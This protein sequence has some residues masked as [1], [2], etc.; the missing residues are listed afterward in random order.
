MNKTAFLTG[1]SSHFY[2]SAKRKAQDIVAQ[3]RQSLIE[4][5]L[6]FQ[7]QFIEEVPPELLDRHSETERNSHFPDHLRFWAFFSQ[8]AS[9]DASCA[10]AVARVQSWA[11]HG[12]CRFQAQ[13][14]AR[15]ARRVRI[16]R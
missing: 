11:E 13:T 10:A 5:T 3:K 14:Q 4:G 12:G 6:D 7:G 1:F 8:V 16:C 9:D 15:I 2:G